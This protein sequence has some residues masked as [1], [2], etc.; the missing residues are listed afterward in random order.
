MIIDKKNKTFDESVKRQ[1]KIYFSRLEKNKKDWR[2]IRRKKR[3]LGWKRIFARFQR[4]LPPP[5]PLPG[6]VEVRAKELG[7]IKVVRFFKSR[8]IYMWL[9]VL[10][11]VVVAAF[12]AWMNYQNF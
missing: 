7:L 6:K 11:S 9:L 10:I 4:P 8:Q 2:D 3:A 12:L 1:V 5:S